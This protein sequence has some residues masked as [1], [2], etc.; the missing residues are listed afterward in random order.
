MFPNIGRKTRLFGWLALGMMTTAVAQDE[1]LLNQS[2]FAQLLS[3]NPSG[4]FRVTEDITL[5]SPWTPVGTLDSPT[6]LNFNG[7]YHVIS[8]LNVETTTANTPTGL[9]GYLVDSW[10]HGV[11]LDQP[12]VLSHGDGSET[13][14]IAGKILRTNITNNLVTGGTVETRGDVGSSGQARY[15]YT[16]GITG[17]ASSSCIEGSLNSARVHTTGDRC[18]AGGVTGYQSGSTTRSNLNTG[19]VSTDGFRAHAG[20]M[21]GYQ[22]DSTT[23]GNLN[24]GAV[25]TVAEEAYAGGATGYQIGSTTSGNLNT[26][27]VSTMGEEAYAGG[28]T[29]FQW[30]RGIT[31]DNVNTG[32]VRTEEEDASAGGTTGYQI[33]STT[34][35]NLNTGAVSAGGLNAYA[36]GTMGYQL[37]SGTTSGN[38]N[39][40]AISTEGGAAYAGGT[41]GRQSGSTTSGNVNTGAVRAEG[42]NADAGGTAGY[43]D[44]SST[45]SGNVNTGAVKAEGENADA[46]GTA[47]YQD[48]S[49]T[50]SGNLYSGSVTTVSGIVTSLDGAMKVMEPVLRVGLNG[51]NRTLWTAGD[52]SQF[53][54]LMGINA[55][56][57]DLQRINNTFPV[58]LN[59]F[60]DP[61]GSVN[62]SLFDPFVWNVCDGYLPFPEAVGRDRAEA[63]GIDCCE[64]GFAC[65]CDPKADISC[66]KPTPPAACLF[67]PQSSGILGHLLYDGQ[68][69]HGIIRTASGLSY[70]AAYEGGEQVALEPCGVYGFADLSLT[71]I[72]VDAAASDGDNAYAAYHIPEQAQAL[73]AVLTLSGQQPVSGSV[74]GLEGVVSLSIDNSH[75]LV[76]T[77]QAI[78]RLP[79]PVTGQLPD[80]DDLIEEGEGIVSVAGNDGDLYLLV[81]Q[82]ETGYQ[83]RTVPDVGHGANFIVSV[84]GGTGL[85]AITPALKVVGQHLHLLLVDRGSIVWR[86]YPLDALPVMFSDL[87][88][89][90]ATAPLNPDSPDPD[91]GGRAGAGVCPGA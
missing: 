32:A 38:L 49:S 69:H 23:S 53:P 72:V 8:G 66:P 30:V 68:R 44:F 14:A 39:T 5:S 36:G 61:G 25:S 65:D 71:G 43:Q 75:I 81:Y 9:F 79:L 76:N 58:E 19:A 86:Q 80:C 51:L 87:W 29:G 88:E 11:I 1:I 26:G 57:R 22:E 63:V 54:M 89:S 82:E 90:E 2:S 31:S 84:P 16:G 34:S 78:C 45:T 13:G 3:N 40:G 50:T 52:D 85:S 83:V 10:V 35:G 21:T 48:S 64:G 37:S 20:G 28:T 6:S 33:G 18:Y 17:S 56:Y 60:A 12:A 55:P 15:A 41:T 74:L 59:Q 70:W 24:S 46:G 77:G 27:A 42:E 7:S 67:T 4:N 47:G 73:L 91:S 62:A